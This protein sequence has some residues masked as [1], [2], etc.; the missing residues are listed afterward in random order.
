MNLINNKYEQSKECNEQALETI[1]H[2][3]DIVDDICVFRADGVEKRHL[4]EE[5][6]FIYFRFSSFESMGD[7]Y[8]ENLEQKCILAPHTKY[9]DD[10]PTLGCFYSAMGINRELCN[11]PNLA[12]KYHKKALEVWSQCKQNGFIVITLR[13]LITLGQQIT[14]S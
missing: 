10:G 14:I 5:L 3:Y 12:Y 7:G 9:I 4:F 11:D 6:M 8:Y 13:R 1:Q 2:T